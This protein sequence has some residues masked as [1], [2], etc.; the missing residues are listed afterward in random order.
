MIDPA[1]RHPAVVLGTLRFVS[2]LIAGGAFGGVALREVEHHGGRL[3][4]GGLVGSA[5]LL[6]TTLLGP[7]TFWKTPRWQS[8]AEA[9]LREGAVLPSART[10]GNP[11]PPEP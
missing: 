8:G 3:L 9:K 10:S 5:V 4:L 1:L 7:A 6:T 2:E 11:S